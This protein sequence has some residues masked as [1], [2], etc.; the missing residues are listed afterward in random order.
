MHSLDHI[1]HHPTIADLRVLH[2]SSSLC[3]PGLSLHSATLRGL[4]ENYFEL[5][6][7][8]SSGQLKVARKPLPLPGDHNYIWQDITKIIDELHIRN[9]KDSRCRAKYNPEVVKTISKT[10][11]TMSCEQTFAW[12]SRFK[13]HLCYAKKSFSFFLHRMIKRRNL[14][15]TYCYANNRRPLQPSIKAKI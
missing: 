4:E 14:Y 11:N 6:Q 2:K 8:V 9:H 13:S 3:S 15:I 7:Y 10:T 12:L 1:A 5:R